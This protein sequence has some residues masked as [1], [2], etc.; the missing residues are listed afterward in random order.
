MRVAGAEAQV[1]LLCGQVFSGAKGVRL[2][3]GAEARGPFLWCQGRA[4]GYPCGV[5]RGGFGKGGT[6]VRSHHK[7]RMC[8]IATSFVI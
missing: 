8:L 3:E 1:L 5:A 4:L 7:S 6:E 2:D